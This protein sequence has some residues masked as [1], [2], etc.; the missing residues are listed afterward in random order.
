V[1]GS[2][3]LGGGAA[4]WTVAASYDLNAMAPFASLSR[5][6]SLPRVASPATLSL[7]AAPAAD[8]VMATLELGALTAPALGA[9]AGWRAPRHPV[10]AFARA[11]VDRAAPGWLVA[12]AVGVLV[13]RTFDR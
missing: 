5:P 8:T 6:I 1:G 11:R 4:P 12:P 3:R 10:K 9:G 2:A 13:E 7:H